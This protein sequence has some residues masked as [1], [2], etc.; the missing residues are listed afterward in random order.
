MSNIL[1]LGII[2]VTLCGSLRILQLGWKFTPRTPNPPPP[3]PPTHT[4]THHPT[5]MKS[6]CFLLVFI[7]I[8]H[9]WVHNW[10]AVT[11]QHAL[12][13]FLHYIIKSY[14]TIKQKSFTQFYTKSSC[15]LGLY[16]LSGRTS[17]TARSREV[18][19]PRYRMLQWSHH[20]EILQASQQRYCRGACQISKI[21]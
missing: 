11:E 18:S 7:K 4:H 9:K 20:Y 1:L 16:S 21:L 6:G 13:Y 10:M 14:M 12:L 19:K 15:D 5:K 8:T 17:Y 2:F 3:P